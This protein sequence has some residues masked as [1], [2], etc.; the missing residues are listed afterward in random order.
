MAIE[1]AITMHN[2]NPTIKVTPGVRTQRPANAVQGVSY[3]FTTTK[4]YASLDSAFKFWVG[5]KVYLEVPAPF[6]TTVPPP[7]VS[8]RLLCFCLASAAVC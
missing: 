4:V 1:C 3:S 5:A 7:L 2:G 6:E 8:D